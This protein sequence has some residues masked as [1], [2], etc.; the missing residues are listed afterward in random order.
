LSPWQYN[1]PGAD[2]AGDARAALS[3]V[4]SV[5]T[6]MKPFGVTPIAQLG[7]VR[8]ELGAFR[9]TSRDTVKPDGTPTAASAKIPH[10][11]SF[12]GRMT[13]GARCRSENTSIGQTAPK[14]PRQE[15]SPETHHA[16]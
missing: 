14:P 1:S 13:C 10:L 8:T 6:H 16:T 3:A 7:S 11:P 15:A 5:P 12:D 4:G 9:S 2:A